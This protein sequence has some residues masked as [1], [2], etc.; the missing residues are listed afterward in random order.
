MSAPRRAAGAVAEGRGAA[1]GGVDRGALV[2]SLDFELLWGVR[3]RHPPDGGAYRENLLGAR[4]AIP[5]ILEAFEE[6]GAA[7]TWATVGFL[8]ASSRAELEHYRPAVL[9]EYDDPGLSPYGDPVGEGEGDDPLHFAGSLIEAVRRCPRQE[10]GTHTYSHYYCLARGQT[11]AAFE[12][13]LASA[14]AIA[15]ARGV[16]VRSIVFPRNQFNPEYAAAL[17]AAGVTCYRSNETGWMYDY[18]HPVYGQGRFQRGARKLDAYVNL[19]GSNL[20]AWGELATGDGLCRLPASRFL[21]PYSPRLRH[22]EPLRLRRIAADIRAAAAARKL[23]HLWW[24]PH[25]FGRHVDENLAVLRAVLAVFGE[26]RRRQGMQSLSMGEVA[27]VAA[28]G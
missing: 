13:D 12:A 16:E 10:V 2:I 6:F 23:Y 20:T 11:R 28:R 5:R 21:R 22:L 14:R 19:S 7:A 3:D 1:A 15:A 25:N 17:A 8:F 26:C 27:E 24:H 4:R 9:P 18:Y